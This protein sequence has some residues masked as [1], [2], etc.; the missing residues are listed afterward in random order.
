MLVY[1]VLAWIL[2]QMSAPSWC[3]W[4]V[5]IAALARCAQALEKYRMK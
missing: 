1:I 4:F 3:W 5:G 2:T